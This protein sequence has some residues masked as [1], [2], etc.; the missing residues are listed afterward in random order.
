MKSGCNCHVHGARIATAIVLLSALMPV[1][2]A[3]RLQLAPLRDAELLW[4]Y[5]HA[6][7][8]PA[9]SETRVLQAAEEAARAWAPCGVR[10]THVARTAARPGA[11]DGISV[12]GW[13]RSLYNAVPFSD[14]GGVTLPWTEDGRAV[15]VD[16]AL[17]PQTV[18]TMVELRMV[19]THEFGHA[20]GLA[21]TPEPG[22]LMSA[23][24]DA[25]ELDAHPRPSRAEM[26]RCRE[27]YRELM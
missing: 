8:P 6:G 23:S 16:I 1:L 21:H 22:F 19:L 13:A 3:D 11:N 4:H 20:A 2:G 14:P 24:F 27:L 18:R 9:V 5:N 25:G 17:V 26:Q 7:A 15:E 12:I 10:I